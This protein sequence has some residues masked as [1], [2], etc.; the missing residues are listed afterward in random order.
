MN[1]TL[2][3]WTLWYVKEEKSVMSDSWRPYWL[4]SPW[5]SP[6][7]NTG[8]DSL[9]LLQGIFPTQGLNPSVP[10]C[11]WILYQLSHKGSPRILERVAYPFSRESSGPRNQTE[12]SC[13]AGGFFTNWAIREAQYV[14][15]ISIKRHSKGYSDWITR[16]V[17]KSLMK[18]KKKKRK[19]K[20]IP[21]DGGICWRHSE[22][23][24]LPRWLWW[25]REGVLG[26]EAE[27]R[28]LCEPQPAICSL[29]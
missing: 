18:A 11:R 28:G 14:N 2:K 7:Q 15:Y 23:A 26:D 12:I 10:H 1:H 4:Y 27:A 16:S 3:G 6:G 8:V 9:S 21:G 25:G 24:L 13:I 5:N 22:E 20:N 29:F 19:K 17:I